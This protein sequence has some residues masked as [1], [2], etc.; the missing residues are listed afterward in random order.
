VWVVAVPDGESSL[1]AVVLD[2]G[3]VQA[4]R[5]DTRG[6][7]PVQI[8]PDQ[9]PPEA[10]PLL[11]WADNQLTL[12][13]APSANASPFTHPIQLQS[14][15]L[16]VFVSAEGS[17]VL[18]HSENPHTT[19]AINALP[20]A[21]ILIDEIGRLLLLSDP[22][23]N[24]T[25]GVLGD[26]L[27]ATTI[28]L[29]ETEPEPRVA[30]TLAIPTEKVIEGISPIWADLTADGQREVIG[31]LSDAIQGAQVVVFAENGELIATG[32]PIGQ[33]YRWRH[34]L[35]VAPFGPNGEHELATVLTPHIGGVVEFFQIVDDTLEKTAQVPGYTSHVLGSRN[36]DMAVAGDFDGDENIEL[37]LPNQERSELG[38]IRRT[39]N[40]AE[41]VWNLPIEGQLSTNIG[42]VTLSKES[43]AIGIGRTDGVLR[44]WFP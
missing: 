4:F 34:Q 28:T 6:V 42:G 15:G 9:L 43:I 8:T 11:R 31:T 33:G 26:Q 39:P 12:V 7:E 22:T 14:L 1:W 24:Y 27:E 2:D 41:V 5:V 17:L 35:A 19:L 10:P 13:V 44:I 16:E 32:Q 30:H 37:L 38:A 21:R 25:H 40:G 36:L 18:T 3:R 20:D 23:S 29:I